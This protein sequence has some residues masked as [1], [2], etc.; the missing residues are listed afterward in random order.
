VFEVPS[1][2][3]KIKETGP[4]CSAGS[5]RAP[6]SDRLCEFVFCRWDCAT[7]LGTDGLQSVSLSFSRCDDAGDW[8][9]FDE[10]RADISEE[11][12]RLVLNK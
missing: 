12:C 6:S 5:T 2:R 1:A 8:K 3:F 9:L 7:E 11:S 4:E 10:Y